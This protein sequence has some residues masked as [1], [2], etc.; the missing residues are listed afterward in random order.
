MTPS[1][2]GTLGI[3]FGTSNSAMAWADAR[4]TARLIPLEGEA[5]SMPTA[6]FY[7][8]ED[9]QTHFGRDAVAQYLAGTDGRLMRSL[10][11]LLGS[12]LLMEKTEVNHQQISFQE[13]VATFLAALRERAAQALGGVAP[14]RVVMGRPVHF[15]DDDPERDALAQRSLL[16]AAQS[17]GFEQVSFQLEP[18]AAA[19]DYERRLVRESLV[20]VV[21]LGGGT[22]DFTVVR[23]GPQRMVLAE[24]AADVLATTG[25]HIGGT[26]FDH[27]LSLEQVMP[28]LGYRHLGPQQREVPSRVFFDL[29]TW[30]LIQW[31]YLPR[32][33]SQAQALRVNYTDT[34][35]HER[36]MKVLR[37]R[38]GHRIAHEV[39]QAKIRCSQQGE[40]TVVDLSEV[41]PALSAPMGPADMQEHLAALLAR[42]VAC[43]RECV[44]R[45]GLSDGA[46]DAIYLTGGS[47]ALRPFQ[48]ALQAEF[49]GVALVEGDLFGGVASGLA[50]SP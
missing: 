47:S 34:R 25:V 16:E 9:H 26:D 38:E 24:R 27:R 46:L 19:L 21:D 41:E 32:A 28:L 49:P 44:Q 12:P 5:V 31:L 40:H 35:L 10:K 42:T 11:S 1:P 39:E 50:Y 7:N 45:A 23:L 37:H 13:I 36:L 33:L 2:Q 43:A 3:D 4:G 29:S 8:A 14:T 48:Q 30:H 22:S 18:I 20:L 15:V 17:V 6:V